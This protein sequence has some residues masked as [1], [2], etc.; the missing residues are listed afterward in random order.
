MYNPFYA[1]IYIIQN[2]PIDNTSRPNFVRFTYFHNY[3]AFALIKYT[4]CV[5]FIFN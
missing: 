3:Y 5:S 1:H 2:I 4:F